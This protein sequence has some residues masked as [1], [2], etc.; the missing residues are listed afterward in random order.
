MTEVHD[1]ER[2]QNAIPQLE[3]LLERIESGQLSSVDQALIEVEDMEVGIHPPGQ[4][5]YSPENLEVL[6]N[7]V[8][9]ALEEMRDGLAQEN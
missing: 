6:A 1:P 4:E 8:R 2:I 9:R 3:E 7:D 5:N